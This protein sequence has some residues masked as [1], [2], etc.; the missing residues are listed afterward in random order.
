[1]PIDP[2]THFNPFGLRR[3]TTK[4]LKHVQMYGFLILHGG[5]YVSYVVRTSYYVT[6]KAPKRN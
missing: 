3:K 1:M 5:I 4:Y 2:I 6:I